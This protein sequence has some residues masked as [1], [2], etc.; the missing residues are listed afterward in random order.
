M[1]FQLKFFSLL[2]FDIFKKIS[3]KKNLKLQKETTWIEIDKFQIFS[4]TCWRC[5]C[6]LLDWK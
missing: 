4:Y 2:S 6:Q 5:V 3:K 1:K